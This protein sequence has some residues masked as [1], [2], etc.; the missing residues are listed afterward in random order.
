[1][2]GRPAGHKRNLCDLLITFVCVCACASLGG[3]HAS[4]DLLDSPWTSQNVPKSSPATSHELLSLE[5]LRAIQRF[6]SSSPDFPRS[7][8]AT[9]PKVPQ[10]SPEITLSLSDLL[11]TCVKSILALPR[12]GVTG[13]IQL[14]VILRLFLWHAKFALSALYG[15][16]P[17]MVRP[18]KIYILFCI[19]LRLL[20]ICARLLPL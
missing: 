19:A 13:L 8:P 4:L 1:M 2:L 7:S 14:G 15:I 6:P 5:N 18:L 20:C 9:S 11:I 10:T 17:A 16:W 3:S 12:N